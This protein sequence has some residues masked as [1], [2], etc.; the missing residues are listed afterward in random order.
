MSSPTPLSSPSFSPS[1][2][3]V[4]KPHPEDAPTITA[5]K[6]LLRETLRISI[7]DGRIFIGTF[8]GTDQPLNI[9]L[10][11]TEEFRRSAVAEGEDENEGEGEGGVGGTAR[12]GWVGRYV[13]QVL[14]PW[15]LVIKV[16]AFGSPRLEEDKEE[17][18]HDAARA[19]YL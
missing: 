9:V 17:A 12:A 4:I 8:A 1:S 13:G 6:A 3:K 7:T 18:D 15:R 16:E 2:P 11:N 14:V 5:V 10:L 19:I